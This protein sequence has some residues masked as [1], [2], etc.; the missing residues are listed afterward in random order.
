MQNQRVHKLDLYRL[1]VQHPQAEVMF[2]LRAYAHYARLRGQPH[3]CAT[4]LREDFA[5]TAAVAA[6]WVALHENHRALA[7]ESDYRT[8]RWALRRTQRDL[9]PRAGDLHLLFADVM[10]IDPPVAPRVEIVAALNFSTFIYHDR[11]TLRAYFQLARRNLFPGGILVL[12][13]FGGPGAQ[14]QMIQRRRVERLEGLQASKPQAPSPSSSFTYLWEQR[15]FDAATNRIDCRIHFEL[16]GRRKITN[17]FRYNWRLWSPVELCELLREAGFTQAQ[18]WADVGGPRY[19]PV[20][21][22]P[23]REDF[24]AYIVGVR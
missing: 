19:Q 7:V 11:A 4:R 20:A 18:I 10:T 16:P 6:T 1:A 3:V 13:A 5:G 21:H 15:T 2:L 8:L 12:D 22:L 14:R 23:L 9:G 24:V 17:A